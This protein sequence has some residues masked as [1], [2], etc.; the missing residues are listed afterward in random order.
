MTHNPAS[1][2]GRKW[3]VLAVLVVV[4]LFTWA[5]LAQSA[6]DARKSEIPTFAVRRGPLT[7]SV[8][9]S[10][11]IKAREKEIL[12]SEL[13]GQTTIIYLIEEGTRVA[14]GDLL[15]EL[16]TSSLEDRDVEQ[17]IKVQN[18]ETAF[19][20]A[21]EDLAVVKNQ[22]E[23]DTAQAELEY[24]FAKEDLTQYQEGEYPK[25]FK[26]TEARITL[27]MEELENASD[28]LDWSEKL[29][30]EKY[31]SETELE[32][33]RLAR[34]RAQ[35]DHQLAVENLK[36]LK[37]Y[38]YVR[39]IDELES[40]IEQTNRALVRVKLQSN[41]EAIQARADLKSKEAEFE[42][43]K[44]KLTKIEEQIKKAKMYAPIDGMVVYASSSRASRRGNREPLDEGQSVRERQELIH[45]P[46]TSA[47]MAEIKVQ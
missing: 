36:L 25:L 32:A 1:K 26:E 38:T 2:R 24:R 28:K 31:I 33:D 44:E 11:T 27:E 16:D 20:R 23:S 6:G 15:V 21:R 12:K 46:T 14:A 9:E 34:S 43:Q 7:I 17:Q 3:T 30:E 37:N 29:F 39:R 10:G 47:I 40:N 35:L 5:M 42:R 13:E 8:S 4:A 41:S 19:I 22:A 18:A 45:L